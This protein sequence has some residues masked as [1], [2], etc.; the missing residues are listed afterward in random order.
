LAKENHRSVYIQKN[1][2]AELQKD[3]VYEFVEK[4][5]GYR[6]DLTAYRMY[7]RFNDEVFI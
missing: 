5:T 4:R 3:D 1:I 2:G 7:S 6:R